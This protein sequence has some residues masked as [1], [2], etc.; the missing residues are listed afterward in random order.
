IG[1]RNHRRVAADARPTPAATASTPAAAPTGSTAALH[2]LDVEVGFVE[3]RF[4]RGG[5]RVELEEGFPDPFAFAVEDQVH[6]VAVRVAGVEDVA[7]LEI[8]LAA[9]EVDDRANLE[10]VAATVGGGVDPQLAL[11]RARLADRAFRFAVFVDAADPA[12]GGGREAGGGAR[13]AR[14]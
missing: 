7:L 4:D 13:R 9:F 11:D 1:R 6:R 14:E 12:E 5:D 3:G 8:L 10:P 2:L